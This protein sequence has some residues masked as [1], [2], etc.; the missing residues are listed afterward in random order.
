MTELHTNVSSV[1]LA[2][3]LLQKQNSG[4]GHPWLNIAT[5]QVE[6]KYSFEPEILAG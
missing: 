3:I 4:S 1:A 6:S 2:G 5:N